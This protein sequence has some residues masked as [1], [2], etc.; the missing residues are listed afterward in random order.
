MKPEFLNIPASLAIRH[1]P[2]RLTVRSESSPLSDVLLCG[3][4]YLSPVPCCSVTCDS[5][6]GGFETNKSKALAQ[7]HQL[8]VV[9]TGLGV[10]CHVLD[11][12]PGLPDLCFTRDCTVVTPWGPV[13]LNPALPHRR[14]EVAHVGRYLASLG[15]APAPAIKSGTIEGGDVCVARDGLAIIGWSGERT[16]LAGAED[17]AGQ[18]RTRGWEVLLCPFDAY[19]LHLDTI[20]CMLNA[21]TAL[22]CTDALPKDFLHAIEARGIHVVPTL[23]AESRQLGC[24]ILSLDGRTILIADGQERL[25]T[26][27]RH[28]GF[29]TILVDISEFAACGGGLHCLTMP[30]ARR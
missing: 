10:R 5:L 19:H 22:A 7:H 2:Q 15:G 24:N 1:G 17:L 8:Q 13:L 14:S 30:L 3:P 29:Q 28:M 12:L 18:F 6:Q 26:A 4:T 11:P 20:F 16:S 25:S 9:L 21:H 23:G 27:L